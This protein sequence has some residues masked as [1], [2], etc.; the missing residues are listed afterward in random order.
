MNFKEVK[1]K[2]SDSEAKILYGYHNETKFLD[3]QVWANSEDLD[4]TAS[5]GESDQG[6]YLLLYRMHLLDILPCGYT[7]LLKF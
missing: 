1:H 4:Q 5:E 2:L 7:T 3:R 6:L